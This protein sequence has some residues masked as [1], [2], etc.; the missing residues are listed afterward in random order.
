MLRR[1]IAIVLLFR[2]LDTFRIFDKIYVMT[3]GGPGSAT[4]TASFY[5]YLTGF[6][7]FRVGYAA[8]MSFLLLMVTVGIATTVAKV[9][10][11]E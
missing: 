3:A 1:L 2:I 11:R 10:H 6:K 9:L 4:E 8:A 5:A 7:Y